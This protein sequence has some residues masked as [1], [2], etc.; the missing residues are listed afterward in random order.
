[1]WNLKNK[2]NEQTKQKQ[3]NM[4]RK[5]NVGYGVWG[6]HGLGGQAK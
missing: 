1:M 4:Y 6:G 5:E 2:A 3:A